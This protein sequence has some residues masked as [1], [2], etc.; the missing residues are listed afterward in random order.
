MSRI[1]LAE[2]R[3]PVSSGGGG[4]TGVGSGF[5]RRAA[6]RMDSSGRAAAAG[7]PQLRYESEPYAWPSLFIVWA[8]QPRGVITHLPAERLS[9]VQSSPTAASA[10]TVWTTRCLASHRIGCL[11]G[12]C[13]QLSVDVSPH[14]L[15]T[16]SRRGEGVKRTMER[17]PHHTPSLGVWVALFVVA[18]R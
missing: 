3:T 6:E 1:V 7:Q 18:S 10:C 14:V 5:K 4:G 15:S 2:S 17:Q 11:W 9:C 12:E 13:L 8:C 16:V